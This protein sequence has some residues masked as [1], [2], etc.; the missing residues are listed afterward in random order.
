MKTTLLLIICLHVCAFA[1]EEGARYL[2]ISHDNFYDA[3][4]PLAQ[5]KHKK[6]MRTKLVRLSET[7]SSVT[8]IRNYIATAYTTWPIPPEYVLFVGAPNY[9]PFPTVSGV[10]SDNYYTNITGDLHNEILSGRLTAHSLTEAQTVINKILLYERTPNIT[11]PSWFTQACCIVNMA[12]DPDDSIYWSDTYH[13]AGLMIAEGFTD[14]DTISNYYGHSA[15]SVIASV[16]SGR[17]IV[18]YRGA[19]VNNWYSPFNVDPNQTQNGSKLPIVLSITC[20]TIGTGS[21]PAAAEYWLL[22]GTPTTPRGASGYFATTTTVI[23]QAYL[24]SAVAKGFFDAIFANG[25]RTFG[26]AC[27]AGRIRVFQMYPYQGGD[28]EYCG[29]TTLGD[30]EMNIWT[31]VPKILDVTHQSSLMVGNDTIDVLVNHQGAPME[32]AF[33]CI[34]LDTVVYEIGHTENDG[35]ISFIVDLPHPGNL[36][37]TITGY[38]LHPYEAVIPVITGGAYV[39]YNDHSIEDSLGNG[40]GVIENGETILLSLILENIGSTPVSEIAATVS[41]GD[42]ML[43]LIDSVAHFGDIPSQTTASGMSPYVFSVSPAS[44]TH[45]TTFN[46]CITDAYNN[47]WSD[48]FSIQISGVGGGSGGEI[49]PDPYG[50]YIYDDMDTITGNAPVFNWYEIA[51]GPGSII[52]QITNSDDDTVTVSLPFTFQY[53]GT[54]YSSIGICTNGF[55]ELG[56][57]TTWDNYNDPIPLSGGPRRLL[58]SFWDNL[59]PGTQHMGHGDIYQYFDAT[60]HRWICEF[61]QVAHRGMG[62]GGQWETFQTI[63]LDPAYYPTPT[64]D[65]EILYQY[66]VVANAISNTVGMED[67]TETR[68]LE[69]VYNSN[70]NQNAATLTANRAILITTRP[71]QTAQTSP[72]LYIIDYIV[73]D[74]SGGNNNGVVEPGETVYLTITLKNGGDTLA[75][76]I[77]GTLRSSDNDAALGDTVSYYGDIVPG[78]NASNTG[79]PYSLTVSAS[80]A[81]ST[82]GLLLHVTANN[83]LYQNDLFFTLYLIIQPGISENSSTDVLQYDIMITPNPCANASLITM[84]I[85]KSSSGILRIYDVSG[86]FVRGFKIPTSQTSQNITVQW[87]GHDEYAHT[88]AAGIYF[89]LLDLQCGDESIRQQA[90]LIKLR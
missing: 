5:W 76:N 11:D 79:D 34:V 62:G 10:Y 77:I 69:Y 85:P 74:S 3:V 88:V 40:N 2:I 24:R 41:T 86:R 12:Y 47:T 8:E 30:P 90:K 32:S 58:A 33:V 1:Q 22:T 63:L 19:G 52:S 81:D 54:N 31:G 26:Q 42:T 23:N 6:G 89:I 28:E 35:T 27:E 53:Y 67:H 82:I 13:A 65:G 56:S 15:S 70:Y 68:G 14:I 44:P 61:Y 39:T 48:E 80:P 7:G 84:M 71:P 51:S 57:T 73:D 37:L 46:I 75:G 49:G 16:N 36:D 17:S 64:G 20:R 38:N 4:V 25:Q 21:T 60:N 83:D 55:F 72:W 66:A 59:N 78:G 43:V 50:Y 18:M 45:H 9:I 87:D 29:F